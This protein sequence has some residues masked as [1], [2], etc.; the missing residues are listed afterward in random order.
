[1]G[2]RTLLVVTT[3]HG[4]AA[5]FM[6]H[7]GAGEAARIWMLYSG[8]SVVARGSP[9]LGD[10]RLADLAATLRPKLG[11]NDDLDP[12]AGRDLSASL[13]R[14]TMPSGFAAANVFAAH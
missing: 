2:K 9:T 7:G 3:D 4:R 10:S 12:R 5:T 14:P 6:H 11:L 8:D 13:E 1:M